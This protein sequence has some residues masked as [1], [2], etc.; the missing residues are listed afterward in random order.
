MSADVCTPSKPIPATLTPGIHT[1]DGI[2]SIPADHQLQFEGTGQGGCQG[3]TDVFIVQIAGNLT[4]GAGVNIRLTGGV[5]SRNIFWQI[6]GY[7][8]MGANCRIK[9]S[10]IATSYITVGAGVEVVG[11]L[12][13]QAACTIGA[14]AMITLPGETAAE[15]DLERHEAIASATISAAN[16]ATANVLVAT[17]AAQ[18]AAESARLATAELTQATR[19]WQVDTVTLND[20]LNIDRL[21]VQQF[22]E[23]RTA[24]AASV[25]AARQAE[26]KTLRETTAMEAYEAASAIATA[27]IA[28]ITALLTASE[29]LL[30]TDRRTATTEIARITA[31]WTDPRTATTEIARITALLTASELLLETER[32]TRTLE[33]QCT[34]V[35]LLTTRDDTGIVQELSVALITLLDASV[36]FCSSIYNVLVLSL[37]RSKRHLRHQSRYTD[38]TCYAGRKD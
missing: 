24:T 7:V 33:T 8:V 1:F 23:I 6:G 29:L 11:R 31:L 14:Y 12:F 28:R 4:L 35:D 10:V 18:L 15:E 5:L 19:Q 38:D 36:C 21:L 13:T 9:G 22:E 32:R 16:E 17:T 37:D 20:A 3:G 2:R 26:T 25:D 27:E 34:N 30:E